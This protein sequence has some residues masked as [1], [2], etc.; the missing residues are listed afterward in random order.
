M[1]KHV[2]SEL[3]E[4]WLCLK[5]GRVTRK[6]P[7]EPSPVPT[8]YRGQPALD[9]ELCTGCAA[10]VQACPSRTI[11]STETDEYREIHFD[12]TRCI[13]CGRCEDV[14][15]DAAVALSPDFEL[16]TGNKD[17]LH[18]RAR[19]HLKHCTQCG[20][21]VGTKRLV[22]KLAEE[23]RPKVGSLDA[24]MDLCTKCRRQS[25]HRAEGLGREVMA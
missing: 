4:A 13:Y 16:S 10:C 14:C 18:I 22:E 19:Y 12:L 7:Y 21:V 24:W 9:P 8:G 5:A 17:D 15:P 2:I 20:A 1:L 3:K 25:A 11:M 6:Y 23:I